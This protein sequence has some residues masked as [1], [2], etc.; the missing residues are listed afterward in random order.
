MV[1]SMKFYL[2]YAYQILTTLGVDPRK[3]ITY[4]S[5]FP[6][7]IY[8]SYIYL[9]QHIKSSKKIKLN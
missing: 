2:R 5:M 3:T 6:R 8:D 1:I 9:S 4:I 7:F